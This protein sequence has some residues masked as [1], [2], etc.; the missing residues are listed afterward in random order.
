MSSISIIIVT[1]NSAAHIG[2]CLDALQRQSA[3]HEVII[4]DNAS[5]DNTVALVRA[6]PLTVRLL[7]LDENRGFAG[8]VNCGAA[9]AQG[10]IIALL[11]P[12]ALPEADWL[13]Q[14]VAPFVDMQI[15]VVG[16]K[17]LGEDGRIQSV[18]S[19]LQT[20]VL[21]S[22]HRGDGEHDA[23]QYD[24]LADVWAV[25][26]AAMAFRRALW[27]ELGGFDEG[28]FPAYWEESGFCERARRAGRRVVVAPQAVVRHAEAT[29]TGKYSAQFYFYYHRNRLRYAAKWL[30]WPALWN[31]FR[32]AE[33]ARLANAPLLDRRVARLVYEGGVPPLAAMRA[34][35][36]AA[37]LATGRELRNGTLPADGFDI[38]ERQ[39]RELEDNSV[40]AEV[41]FR[42]RLPLVARLRTAWNNVATRWYVRPNFD[43]QTRFNLATQRALAAFAEQQAAR[44]AADALDVALLAWRLHSVGKSNDE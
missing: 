2:A 3:A 23:G 30:P 16:S 5:Q 9:V 43:Q 12:D 39:L 1:Y 35:E 18:G 19:L 34:D 25:H 27:Q 22:A 32:P 7:P 37:V 28:F 20:P 26:G 24:E 29:A 41:A 4:V 6:H 14:L 31:E 13:E 10:E 15:G 42:S 38:L 44:A 17:V 36:R 11:N 21:L 8:G 33:R 40:H